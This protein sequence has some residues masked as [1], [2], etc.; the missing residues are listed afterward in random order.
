LDKALIMAMKNTIIF[1]MKKNQTVYPD[2]FYTYND[3]I[4]KLED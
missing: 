4:K 1:L 3:L 2:T